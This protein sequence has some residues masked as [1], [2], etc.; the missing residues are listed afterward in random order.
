MGMHLNGE[1][2]LDLLEGT[3]SEAST[4]HLSTCEA[5]RREL[6]GLRATMTTL[7]AVASNLEVPEPSPLF[8]EHV[9]TRVRDA[10]VADAATA[11]PSW[12]E[13]WI[14]WRAWRVVAPAAACIVVLVAVAPMFQAEPDS[15]PTQESDAA[16]DPS[17]GAPVFGT[18]DPSWSLMA[19]LAAD[20]DW[21]AAADAGL[22]APGG[23]D[24]AIMDLGADERRELHRLLTEE[25][26]R[27][28]A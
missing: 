11:R 15:V 5:C 7:A 23:V 2:L 20:L 21:D 16:V 14:S 27:S 6:A 4:P 18:D 10:I 22:V 12:T 9:S 26:T 24:R 19:D 13:H 8:W 25:L 3:R 17:V 1:E 28:G